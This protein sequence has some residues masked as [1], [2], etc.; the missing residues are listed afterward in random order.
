MIDKDIKEMFLKKN[1]EIIINKLILDYCNN[2]DSLEATILNITYLE[3]A[4]YKQKILDIDKDLKNKKAITK[5]INSFETGVNKAINRL[6]EE[7][8]Q[9][10]TKYIKNMDI[11]KQ[12]DLYLEKLNGTTVDLYNS[13]SSF[14][15]RYISEEV[16]SKLISNEWYLRNDKKISFFINEKLGKDLLDKINS[17]I[18][19]R[20]VIIFN[21]ARESYEKYLLLNANF[22]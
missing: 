15:N 20:D 4:I 11:D 22:D 13:F 5:I 16:V 6:L 10:C 2:M 1:K 3:F 8:K 19:D 18:K 9:S 14:L 12:L 17:Q 7:K 21:N